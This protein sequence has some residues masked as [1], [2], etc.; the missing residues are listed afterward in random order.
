MDRQEAERLLKAH[1]N[2]NIKPTE[3]VKEAID[4]ILNQT[5]EVVSI[6]DKRVIP[7]QNRCFALSKG[8]LCFYC[9]MECPHRQSEF[10]GEID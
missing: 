2:G 7:L 3:K 1:R 8:T 9:P 4:F 5:T 6:E 10:R